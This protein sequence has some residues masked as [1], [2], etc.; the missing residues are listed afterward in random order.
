MA[1]G[2]GA[3]NPTVGG[4]LGTIPLFPLNCEALTPSDA[5][6]FANPTAITVYGAGNLTFTPW[7][8]DGAANITLTITAAMVTNGP[9]V[10]PCMV[11]KVLSTGTTATLIY[12]GW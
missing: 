4:T 3:R 12:G 10:L 7:G 6:V 2:A 8:P 9:F 1:V 11:R 5:T